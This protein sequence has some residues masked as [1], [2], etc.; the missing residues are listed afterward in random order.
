MIGCEQHMPRKSKH[1]VE[2]SHKGWKLKAVG[3]IGIIGL[4]IIVLFIFVL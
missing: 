1:S 4:I 3:L 2:I